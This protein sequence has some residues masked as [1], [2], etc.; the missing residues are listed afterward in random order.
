LVSLV[1]NRSEIR[2]LGAA[3]LTAAEWKLVDERL[4]SS[5]VAVRPVNTELRRVVGTLAREVQ[6]WPRPSDEPL[7][8]ARVRILVSEVLLEVYSHLARAS[9]P[10]RDDLVIAA[11]KFLRERLSEPLSV[12]TLA[13]H[14]GVS[15]ARLF[16]AFRTG[17]GMSPHDYL[18]RARIERAG[19]LLATTRRQVTD[20]ALDTGFGSSQ[21]FS[22][23]F[24]KFTGQ[25]PLEYRAELPGA[26]GR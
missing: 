22:T 9:A 21:Y 8:R 26:K 25:T 17:A 19:A 24:R 18:L 11:Q 4:H 5:P 16:A 12:S 1:F 23:V 14:L 3:S 10:A 7:R 13:E 15:R 6:S 2:P 20:V